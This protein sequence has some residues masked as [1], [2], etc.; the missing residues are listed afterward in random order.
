MAAGKRVSVSP[1]CLKLLNDD[2]TEG[3]LLGT[4]CRQCGE[5]FFGSVVFCQSC[6]SDDM[7]P[8]ELSKRGTLFSYTIVRAPP[9]GWPGKVPYALGQVMLPEGPHVLSE[10]LDCPFEQIKVGM[11]L[12]LDMA[13]AGEDDQGNQI[14]VYKWRRSP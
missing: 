6:T 4:R 9:S 1:D 5:H 7:E 13:I 8:V 10:V 12:E 11:D 3:V 14:V 2:G